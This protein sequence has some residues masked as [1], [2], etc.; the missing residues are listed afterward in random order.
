VQLAAWL[1]LVTAPAAAEPRVPAAT[2]TTPSS[3]AH[4][5]SK[6]PAKARAKP[7][8]H[9]H[10][11]RVHRWHM[12]HGYAH[13]VWRW[14]QR[15]RGS[16]APRDA[17]GRPELVLES[18][19]TRESVRLSA[20]T[21]RG[22]FSAS[23]L[24]RA[25]HLLRDTRHDAEFPVDP[26]LLDVVY[27]L[28]RHFRAPLI[29]VISGYRR[30]A[31]YGHSRHGQGRAIDLVVPGA[32]NHA[33]AAYVRKLGFCGVGVYPR[34]G[35]V[36]VDVRS[37]SYYWVDSSGPG[38][39]DRARPVLH[40]LAKRADAHALAEG[41]PRPRT[42]VRPDPNVEAVWHAESIG[43]ES[44]ADEPSSEANADADDLKADQAAANAA[45]RT[46]EGQ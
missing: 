23:E 31:P 13:M 28:E 35:F 26:G 21:D 17:R 33:V 37:S 45:A 24:D 32:S 5:A 10:Y 15:P 43:A 20:T 6:P 25:A 9:R 2:Q 7:H 40:R 16:S 39:A 30:P 12:P 1:V 34:S 44:R 36:H 8:R 14:H 27:R 38:Q 42:S 3:T 29:R 19:N 22:G 41:C 4:E 46:D 18:V 11:R